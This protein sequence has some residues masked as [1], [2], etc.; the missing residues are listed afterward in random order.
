VSEPLA[1]SPSRIESFLILVSLLT[2]G[3]AM[4]CYMAAAGRWFTEFIRANVNFYF[5]LTLALT[6]LIAFGCSLFATG[7]LAARIDPLM[8]QRQL[9]QWAL[10]FFVLQIFLTPAIVVIGFLFL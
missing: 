1:K 6:V 4:S 7:I 2:P 5:W 3:V 10:L 8:R 9:V